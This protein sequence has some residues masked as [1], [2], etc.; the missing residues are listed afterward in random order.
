MMRAKVRPMAPA[1]Y[2]PMPIT[3][4]MAPMSPLPRYWLMRT[5]EPLW[6]PNIIS[7]TTNTGML[8]R[9][10][11]ASGPS[12]MVPTIKVST[13]PRELVMRFCS[14]MGRAREISLG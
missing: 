5:E 2:M 12:P 9:V 7:C 1:A 4:L 14:R 3:R 10:T 6:M 8:A 11:P 13:S